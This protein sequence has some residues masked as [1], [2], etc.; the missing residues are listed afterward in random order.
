MKNQFTNREIACIVWNTMYPD[1]RPFSEIGESAKEEWE[2]W[3]EIASKVF[4]LN[5]TLTDAFI[6]DLK[7]LQKL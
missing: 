1:R 7:S 2:K 6:A 3:V 5:Q 4:H